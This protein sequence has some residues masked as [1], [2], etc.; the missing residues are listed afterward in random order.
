[1][2]QVALMACVVF[3]ARPALADLTITTRTNG[4]ERKMYLTPDKLCVHAEDGIMIFDAKNEVV[5][6]ADPETKTVREMTREDIEKLTAMSQGAAG[7]KTQADAM[8]EYEDMMKEAREQAMEAIKD[9]PDDQRREA[10]KMIN[11]RMGAAAPGVPGSAGTKSYEPMG[12]SKEIGDYSCKGYAIKVGDANVGEVWTADLDQL[13]IKADDVVV[14]A[15][16]RQ[17]FESALKGSP[18]MEDAMNEFKAFDPQSEGFIGF[19]VRQVDLEHG[20]KK[21]TELVSV[22]KG[23]IEPGVFEAGKDYKKESL[24]GGG[25]GG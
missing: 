1:M 7:G 25:P 12:T 6:L 9:L 5:R 13:D 20:E 18:F 11:E 21:I 17:F 2:V 14:L 8:A 3:A 15:K 10:E 4:V 24:M 19:P 16:M 22:V 23:K